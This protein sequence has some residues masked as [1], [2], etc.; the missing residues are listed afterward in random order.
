MHTLK[1]WFLPHRD[2]HFHP[3]LLRPIG[4]S[5]VVLL[6]LVTNVSYN[7]AE[8]KKFQV[9][10]YA[11][12]ISASEIIALSNNERTSRGLGALATS[13]ALTQAAQAKAAH[14]FANNYWAH[15]APD[16]T[17]PWY[18]MGQAG[19]AYIAAGEN[20]AKDFD[21]SVGVVNGWMNSQGH[22]DN[23]LNTSFLDTGVAAVN[24]ILLGQETTLVV[25][26]YGATA[27]APAPVPTPPPPTP[28]PTAPVTPTTQQTPP[29]QTAESP[30]VAAAPVAEEV[31][32]PAEAITTPQTG[33]SGSPE[34]SR[35]EPPAPPTQ[36]ATTVTQEA[37]TSVRQQINWAQRVSIFMLS[38]LLLVNILK[39]TAVWRAQRRGLRHIWLRSHPA[40]QYAIIVLAILANFTTGVGVIR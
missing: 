10:G 20:L 6:L 32:E 33:S 26:M 30:V 11:T 21:T 17:T 28:A 37:S 36:V 24:G 9:L 40:A 8:A 34:T 22:R 5:L 29:N 13:A 18:F 1:S 4:L 19:Y 12:S 23:I 31:A 2:N 16:G 27:A 39:H 7:V 3:R 15:V 25:A 14:M 35:A 38:V